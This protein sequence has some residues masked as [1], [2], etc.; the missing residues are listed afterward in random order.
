MALRNPPL[1]SPP[2]LLADWVEMKTILNPENFFRIS[3]LKRYWDTHREEED[4]DTAGQRSPEAD[5]DIDGA[6]GVDDDAFFS[7]ISDELSERQRSLEGSYPFEFLDEKFKLKE[8]LSDGA[9]IYLFCL[10]LTHWKSD[11]VMDGTWIPQIDNNIRDLFQACSTLAA[12]GFVF[13]CA[14]SFGWPRP[15]GNPPFLKKLAEVCNQFG[16]GEAVDEIPPG[17]TPFVKDSEIDI[18]AW[19]PR[20]DNAPGTF[21]MLGQVAS[22]DNWE[23]KSIKASIDYFHRVWFKKPPASNAI[24]SIFIPQLVQE[25]FGGSRAIRMDQLSATYG[26]IFDRMIIPYC[27]SIGIDLVD[28]R[29]Q[30]FHIE[31]RTEV[32][33]II[34]WVDV[35]RDSLKASSQAVI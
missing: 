29:P 16:E 30:P 26:I 10:L 15:E 27:A 4:T 9:Y 23:A 7:S 1:K 20:P 11:D 18:I 17:A 34:S 24:A 13:G 35:Q 14:V 32:A 5:T 19:K 28:R 33:K 12:A 22:G 31:R 6:S 8:E 3:L 2:Y 21:Y 25:K